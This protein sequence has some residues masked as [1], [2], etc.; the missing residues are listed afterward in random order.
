MKGRERPCSIR[1]QLRSSL[2]VLQRSVEPAANSGSWRLIQ[3]LR[4]QGPRQDGGMVSPIALAVFKLTTNLKWVGPSIG[5]SST[6][7][8]PAASFTVSILGLIAREFTRRIRGLG[9]SGG[10]RGAGVEPSPHR[11]ACSGELRRQSFLARAQLS[12]PY[13]PISESTALR[14]PRLVVNSATVQGQV[15]LRSKL[16]LDAHVIPLEPSKVASI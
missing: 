8:R 6:P 5:N 7:A 11:S 14:T 2:N 10:G 1:P 3:P 4:R 12:R 16:I 13:D 15:F 9:Q